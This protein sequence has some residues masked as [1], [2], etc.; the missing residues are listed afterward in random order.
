MKK[1]TV[2][3]FNEKENNI[4]D[5]AQRQFEKFGYS[6]V[7]MDE[8]AENLGVVKGSL[9]YYF[10]NKEAVYKAVVQREQNNF[11]A[12]LHAELQTVVS[13]SDKLRCYFRLRI[14]F[15]KRLFNLNQ[16][17]REIAHHLKPLYTNL[18]RQFSRFEQQYL[19]QILNDGKERGEFAFSS[20]VA[21][22]AVINHALYGLRQWLLHHSNRTAAAEERVLT[23]ESCLFFEILITGLKTRT[24]TKRISIH[25]KKRN[26][27]TT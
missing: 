7:T 21:V 26:S 4:L 16:M 3:P 24:V 2:Q 10:P 1:P 11:L 27:K 23:Q 19:V 17:N 14:A 12:Q 13:A 5:A 22:A 8:I 9:Y 20:A 15:T 6:K 18:F 25:G